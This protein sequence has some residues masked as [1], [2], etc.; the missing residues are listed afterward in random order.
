MSG[1]LAAPATN[2]PDV[3]RKT[4]HGILP[5]RLPPMEFRNI[6]AQGFARVASCTV[7]VA[8]ADPAT[9]A[10]ADHPS[11][12]SACHDDGVAVALFPELSLCGYAIDDLLLQDP[13][14]TP[15]TRRWSPSPRRPHKLRPL[16]VVGAP[17]RTAT[18]ST[19][20]RIVIHRGEILGVVPKSHLPN[21]REFYE[22]RH[23]ASG[24][25]SPGRGARAAG[26]PGAAT[27]AWIPFGPD[28][29][30][31]AADDPRPR[32]C[33]SRSARTCG[34]R[35]RRATE[36]PWPARRCCSTSAASPI[37]V[38]SAEDRHLLRAFGV[39]RCLAAYVYAAAMRR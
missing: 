26:W 1:R 35:C 25:R 17:L 27:M 2:L 38:D 34:C 32:P 22:K 20:A 37:T 29:L 6:Y 24:R 16:V 19:T 28:L 11:R 15:S 23:F 36:R 39:A 10:A 5:P 14:W 31:E 8:L 18:G 21:Y 9:N 12:S 13:C 30:F 33:T 4:W 3:A 7:P